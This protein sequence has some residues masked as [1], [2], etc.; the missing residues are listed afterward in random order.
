M[1]GLIRLWEYSAYLNQESQARRFESHLARICMKFV[2]NT[3]E[4]HIIHS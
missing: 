2:K 1:G 4:D 3:I